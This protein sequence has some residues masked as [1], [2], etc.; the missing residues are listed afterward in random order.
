MVKHLKSA[1]ELHEKVPPD[2]YFRSIKRNLLQRLWHN[3]RFREVG[4]IIEPKG[5]II[6]DI[7]SADGV[8]TRLILNK[9]KADK[10]IGIDA[11]KRS[12][13]WANKHWKNYKRMRFQVG[14]A[15]NLKFKDGYFDAVF[16]LE[17]LEHVFNPTRVLKEIKRV[18]KRGGYVVIL[19]PSDS[20][21]FRAV[22]LFLRKF[23]WA[24]IWED[25]HIQSF[26][27]NSLLKLV[28]RTGYKVEVDKKF[29]LGML[30]VVKARKK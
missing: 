16:V 25:T 28:R 27:E 4:K 30:H 5:G 29:W 10:V 13:A 21:L 19:V 8:F 7:G 15:H 26:K 14:D 22:W 17:V 6:L 1:S 9:S 24:K 18:L 3:S 20:L 12:V 2:W 23:W 11:L